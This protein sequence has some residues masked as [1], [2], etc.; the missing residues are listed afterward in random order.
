MDLEALVLG[1]DDIKRIRP[2]IYNKMYVANYLKAFYYSNEEDMLP[3]IRVNKK[4]Y[5]LRHMIGLI[6]ASG[7]G[8]GIVGTSVANSNSSDSPSTNMISTGLS[9]NGQGEKNNK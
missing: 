9:P 3:W 7:V 8:T 2:P 1:L 6:Y 4:K 5:A